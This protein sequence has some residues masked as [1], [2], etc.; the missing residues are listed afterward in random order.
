MF[1]DITKAFDKVWHEGFIFELKHNGISGKM[2]NI[3]KEFLVSGFQWSVF[4]WAD[5]DADV[6][7][8]LIFGLFLFLNYI[9]D[10]STDL[11]SNPKFCADYTKC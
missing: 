9:N 3:I 1:L 5:F 10:L 2:L 6:L 7:Q 4:L 11:T 8:G